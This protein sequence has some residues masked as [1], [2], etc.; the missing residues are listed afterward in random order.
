MSNEVKSGAL[1]RHLP[2]VSFVVAALSLAMASFQGWINSRN[3]EVVQRDISRR[4][5]I[6]VCK[7][8]I[9]AFFAVKLRVGVLAA[10]TDGRIGASAALR[11]DQNNVMEAAIAASRFA[12]LATYL[13]NFEDEATRVRFTALANELTRLVDL[14]RTRAIESTTSLF[15]IADREFVALNENCA[16]NARLAFS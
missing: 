15:D 6:R 8:V 13:A 7:E 14:L 5:V 9:E 4:E 2:V 10:G 16:R 12:A 3:L 11:D 1:S